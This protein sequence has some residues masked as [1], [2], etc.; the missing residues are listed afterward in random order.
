MSS[1]HKVEVA[2]A[3]SRR[4]RGLW[5]CR[6]PS[7]GRPG[8]AAL[9]SP[10]PLRAHPHT[11]GG[12]G[13]GVTGGWQEH[14]SAGPAQ[15]F[16][17]GTQRRSRESASLPPS[18]GC[19]AAVRGSLC[20]LWGVGPP[21][22]SPSPGFPIRWLHGLKNLPQ[23]HLHVLC[24]RNWHPLPTH[25]VQGAV[26]CVQRWRGQGKT[27]ERGGRTS[28]GETRPRGCPGRPEADGAA[29]W[30]RARE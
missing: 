19:G 17:R 9:C 8:R 26:P 27:Q 18:E 2:G 29:P 25:P 7:K 11:R 22:L 5:P 16:S 3:M 15:R 12:A 13:V 4:A 28:L 20:R 6:R 24:V 21:T 30:A 10:L 1:P 14:R 23:L